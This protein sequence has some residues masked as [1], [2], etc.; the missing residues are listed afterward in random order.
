MNE[1]ANEE[2]AREVEQLA[3]DAEAVANENNVETNKK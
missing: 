3:A 2:D 1:R